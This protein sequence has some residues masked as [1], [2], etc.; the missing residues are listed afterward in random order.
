MPRWQ[1]TTFAACA[2]IIAYALVYA[3]VD[4]GK[5]PHLYHDQLGHRWLLAAQMSGL[6]SGY[7]G[8]VLW[9]VLAGLAAA[10]AAWLITGRRRE[11]ASARAV[12]LAAAWAGTA[13][14]IALG[15]F[16]WNNWP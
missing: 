4:Y 8:L 6:P 3:G 15:Y 16:A 11:A 1:R 12:G 5:V 9:A 13:V 2:G 14:A 7:P 10:G